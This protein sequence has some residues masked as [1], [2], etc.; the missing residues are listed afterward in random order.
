MVKQ[1]FITVALIAVSFG[2]GVYV[3]HNPSCQ[4]QTCCSPKAKEHHEICCPKIEVSHEIKNQETNQAQPQKKIEQTKIQQFHAFSNSFFDGKNQV[5][6]KNDSEKGWLFE[7]KDAKSGQ[8]LCKVESKEEIDPATI[9]EEYRDMYTKIKSG[10][11]FKISTTP[12]I[13]TIKAG[14]LEHE[15]FKNED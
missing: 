15:F 10:T 3:S 2:A 12:S 4:D 6:L 14:D 9:P 8:Q 11:S 7:V 13:I 5:T 1:I